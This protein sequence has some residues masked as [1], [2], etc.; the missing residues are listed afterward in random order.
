MDWLKRK[1]AILSLAMARVESSSLKQTSDALGSEGALEQSYHTGMLADALLRGEITMEVKELRWRL[2][3]VLSAANGVKSKIVGYDE[4]NLPIVESFKR[5]SRRELD[6]VKLDPYDSYNVEMVTYNDDITKSTAEAFDLHGYDAEPGEAFGVIGST[7]VEDSN[8]LGKIKFNDMMDAFKSKKSIYIRREYK[9]KFEL[10]KYCK[11]L[12]VRNIDGDTKLLEFY[13]SIYPDEYDR[14][15]RLLLSEIKKCMKNPRISDIIEFEK[16]G[17][18]T[19]K[20]LGADDGLEFEYKIE[21]HDKIVEFGGFYVLK[22]IAKPIVN[23]D[24]VYEK[25]KLDELEFRY[26]NKE[27]KK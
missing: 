3:K 20:V 8:T 9:P 22:F 23:G 25:Y 11:K 15:S 16:V 7:V 19:D 1:M 10:E 17:F 2:Y 4:D 12:I 6:K 14:R 5:D 21:K 13:V 27:A 18:I 24:N 26:E